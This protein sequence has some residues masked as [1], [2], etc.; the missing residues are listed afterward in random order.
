M[1][2]KFFTE[3]EMATL[4]QNPYVYSVSPTAV[5]LTKA[6]K[7]IFYAE[8]QQGAYPRAIFENTA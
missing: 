8:Y 1:S 6:F 5:I 4:R 2:R 7:E 3:E